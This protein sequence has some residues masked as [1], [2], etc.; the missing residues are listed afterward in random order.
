MTI[1]PLEQVRKI[2][3]L[4]AGKTLDQEQQARREATYG[5]FLTTLRDQ[6]LEEF[7]TLHHEAIQL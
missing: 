3:D 1:P 6:E 4:F 2:T 7:F 5:K